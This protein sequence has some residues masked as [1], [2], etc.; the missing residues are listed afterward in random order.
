MKTLQIF[1]RPMC[2]STGVCGPQVDPAL[3]QFASDL[4]WLKYEGVHVERF[5]LG[6][7]PDAFLK[8]PEVK[9]ILDRSGTA[10]L[11]VVMVDGKIV[12][13]GG[14]PSRRQLAVWMGVADPGTLPVASSCCGPRCC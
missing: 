8:Q 10:C 7:Q 1:D 4:E 12:S 3:A 13:R 6:Q 5:N 14:Y 9:A 2:C 11:P